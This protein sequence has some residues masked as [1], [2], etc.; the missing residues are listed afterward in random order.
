MIN[1][2]AARATV[3]MPGLAEGRLLTG[4]NE[5]DDIAQF[6]LQ[7]GVHDVVIKLG[8]AGARGWTA[9]GE[10]AQSRSFTVTPIDTVGA[11]DGFAA[12][13]LAA[14]LAGAGLQQRL[15]QA[16]A[17][18][19]LVTTRRGD[20]TAMPTRAEVEA[21]MT[22]EVLPMIQPP[23]QPPL[24]EEHVTPDQD[25][26]TADVVI[27]GSGMGGGTLAWALKDTGL[28]VLIVERGQF[29]PRSRRTASL[30]TCSSRSAMSPPSPGMTPRPGSRFSPAST[31]GW[32]A[33][34]R[35]TAPACRGF[36]A[37][38]SR[39]WPITTASPRGRSAMTT[40]SRSMP[41]LKSCSRCTAQSE[42]TPPSQSTTPYPYPP[43]SHEPAV[44]RLAVR[45]RQQG[46][47]PFHMANGMHLPSMAERRAD[48]TSDGSPSPT[49]A[50]SDAENRAVRPA[51]ES[52]TVR[53]RW[54][55]TS[56][57]CT[58]APMGT[59][60]P[61]R[62]RRLASGRFG[63]RPRPCCIRWGG[64]LNGLA[65]EL[66]QRPAPSRT[67]QLL[68]TAGPQLHGPQQHVLHGSEPGPP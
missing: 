7:H 29:L 32:A 60:L 53:F 67:R 26:L 30:T 39:K 20:L 42:R 24:R 54:A 2:V 10:N 57:G 11:G 15:D 68:R 19:A 62:R 18:G 50:K 23:P 43:L 14:L 65:V 66:G 16:A 27:I 63:S 41:R 12:G 49:G 25:T 56:A 61:L 64:Q 1:T 35:C 51:L 38:T 28:D 8:A 45:L 34:P 21:L 4:A 40:S 36:A 44:E 3:V 13:Y 31:T 33:T 46:L 55:R 5:L 52:P 9:D 48:A 47:H 22:A 37:A 58:P 6:Y 59:P 17:V